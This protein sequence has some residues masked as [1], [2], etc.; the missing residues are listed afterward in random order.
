M[1]N[2]KK[3]VLERPARGGTCSRTAIGGRW[4]RTAP[5]DWTTGSTDYMR[6]RAS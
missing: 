6:D 4:T 1:G 5:S 3:V 2:G